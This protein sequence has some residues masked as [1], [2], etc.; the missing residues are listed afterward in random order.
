MGG[1]PTS[2]GFGEGGGRDLA[3]ALLAATTTRSGSASTSDEASKRFEQ[4][5][6]GVRLWEL[7]TAY[8]NRTDVLADLENTMSGVVSR[9]GGVRVEPE[10]PARH[11]RLRPDQLAELAVRYEAGETVYELAERFGINRKTVGEILRSQGVR[12][13]Y[14]SIEPNDHAEVIRLY[15]SG[16]SLVAVGEVFGVNAGTIRAILA[17]HDVPRRAVGTNQWAVPPARSRPS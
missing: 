5:P 3:V 4:A 12:L 7:L 6:Q 9:R 15:E 14:R 10:A 2:V 17:R 1:L 8:A 16:L 13:R 11:R